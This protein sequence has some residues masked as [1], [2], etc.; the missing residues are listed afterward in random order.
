MGRGKVVLERISNKV[1]RQVTFGKR[2]KGLLKKASELSV[3]CD[4]E[5]ALILFSNEGKLFH[6]GST[7]TK[8]TIDRYRQFH[9]KNTIEGEDGEH[10]SQSICQ[11]V[12]KLNAKYQ[13][14]QL[15]NRHLLGEDLG[16]LSLKKLRNLEKQIEGTLS[17]ARKFK[18]KKMLERVEALR[19]LDSEL[20]QQNK[21]LKE[22][23][24]KEMQLQEGNYGR[25]GSL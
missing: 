24:D 21:E 6:F 19:K 7:G 12:T 22:K 1:N 8:N 16:S 14:L 20:E 25:R 11:A 17:K 2:K 13:S 9:S 5:V 15:L 4:A 10:E 23:I 18:T 3:L